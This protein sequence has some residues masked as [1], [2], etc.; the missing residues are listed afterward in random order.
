MRIAIVSQYFWP[1]NFRINDLA[2]GLVERGHE[3]TVLSSNPNYPNRS[4]FDHFYKSPDCYRKLSTINIFRSYT[5]PRFNG[6]YLFLNYL[7]FAITGAIKA[8]ELRSH[9]FDVIFFYQPS[10]ATAIIPALTLGFLTKTP[11]VAWILDLWPDTLVDLRVIKSKVIIKILALFVSK[12][13]SRCEKVL[14]QSHTFSKCLKTKIDR[15]EKVDVLFSWSEDIFFIRPLK[16]S[17]LI[18]TNSQHINFVFAGN[19]GFSQGLDGFLRCAEILHRVYGR[20]IHWYFIGDG[21]C[22]NQLVK[23]VGELELND[24]VFFLE[25]VEHQELSS[26]YAAADAL[27]ISL[28]ASDAFV[29]TIPA[30]LQDYMASGKPVLGFL[31]GDG[32]ELIREA[33]CGSVA[34]PHDEERFIRIVRRFCNM[35]RGSRLSLGSNGEKYARKYFRRDQAIEKIESIFLDVKKET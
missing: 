3:V 33:N 30:K 35:S 23:L 22:R 2:K 24:I 34:K 12:T 29:K 17:V 1:E 11:V 19:I 5:L 25:P 21:R 20:L 10:P 13:L 7:S 28:I 9:K 27:L 4:R 31:D 6:K 16:K 15:P 14:G 32:A 26:I 18:S 8:F